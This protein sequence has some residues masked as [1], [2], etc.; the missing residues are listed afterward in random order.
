MRP[1]ELSDLRDGCPFTFDEESVRSYLSSRTMLITGAGGSIGTTLSQHAARLSPEHLV[2]VDFSE[3]NLYHLDRTLSEQLPAQTY[4]LCL[5]DVNDRAAMQRVF[6][7]HEPSVVVHAAAYK[8]VHLMERHPEAAFR[9]NTLATVRLL[10]TCAQRA[11][12]QFV[13]V[14]TDKAVVPES[15]LGRTKQLS[16]WYVQAVRSD[17]AGTG[18]TCKV[19][20]FGNVFG[21]RGSV[22]PLFE[23]QIASG[24]P[25]TLTHP[26]MVRYF[27]SGHE[28]AGLILQTLLLDEGST[29]VFRMGKP[30][31]IETLARRLVRHYR[32]EAEPDDW[33]RRVGPRPGERMREHLLAPNETVAD[34]S[35]PDIVALATASPHDRSTLEDHLRHLQT[36]CESSDAA[37]LREAL[38]TPLAHLPAPQP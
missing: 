6:D 19:V 7:R 37:L 31:R 10:E 26:S 25:V 29:Y 12:D 20:R 33:I 11:V 36:L 35:H 17:R 15:V 3:H 14:S 1:F 27:M 2:L 24:G 22:V 38:L 34:T 16:E 13:Y 32:P 4:T 21:S 9:N 18:C 30:V 28:A 8:H 5:T 23:R